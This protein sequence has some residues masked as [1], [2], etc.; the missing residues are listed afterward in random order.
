MVRGM[1][2]GPAW[3]FL[4][5]FPIALH[6]IGT[7]QPEFDAPVLATF[8]L[9]MLRMAV[10]GSILILCLPRLAR[11]AMARNIPFFIVYLALL[12]ATLAL[13]N[14]VTWA[15]DPDISLHLLTERFL[16][17]TTFGALLTG[18]LALLVERD[19]RAL[20]TDP[21]LV[22]VWWPVRLQ[23]AKAGPLPP[24]MAD[25]SLL[26]PSLS[27]TVRAMQAQNQYVEVET[28]EKRH[29]LRIP[30]H[31]AVALMPD[32]A[33]HRVH[34]SWW[35]ADHVPVTL[36]RNGQNYEVL[37]SSG[38]A[39]PV[40]RPNLALVRTLVARNGGSA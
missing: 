29:L 7:L 21:A 32:N 3:L 2:L 28:P 15:A 34:R 6:L 18:I 12:M 40:S 20:G 10:W 22:P 39:F 5:F 33:G 36:R 25:I 11:F 19:I 23:A 35:L 4:T 16:R 31:T 14:A 24:V 30:F 37:D 8:A 26:D 38:R 27:G 1:V 13:S 17:Q 9:Y